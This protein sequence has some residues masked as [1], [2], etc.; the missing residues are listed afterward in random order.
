MTATVSVLDASHPLV[1]VVITTKNEERNIER[2]LQSILAQTYQ[3]I[4]IIVVDNFSTDQT[5]EI[6]Q[7][8]T[9]K[10]YE[11]G[12]ERS[13]QRNFGMIDAA[14]GAYVIFVDADM[15]LSPALIE[16]CVARMAR[17]DCVALHI[18]EIVLGRNFW[19]QVRRFERTFYDGTP[20]DGARFFLR[21]A[22][23]EVGGFD[24]ELFTEGS[25]EDW[26]IDKLIKRVGSIAL[27]S[28]R[29]SE[30]QQWEKALSTY[31]QSR[32][33]AP[34]LRDP[35]IY[36]NESEF[37]LGKYLRK[38]SY[39]AKG[40][41]GYIRKWGKTDPDIQ[42][43][44]GIGYR[45]FGVFIEQGKWRKLLAHPGLAA[46]MYFLRFL[47]GLTFIMRKRSVAL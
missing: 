18:R 45:Y 10:V 29:S 34:S 39:Y 38:K 16:N 28:E 22:F 23:I 43:Q 33:V 27:L 1:S 37:E 25:G 17:G 7:R 47:V 2:C 35:H 13:A 11:K 40:F 14:S 9:S 31:V 4:E 32:G 6:A 3:P 12:P 15:I 46:G 5:R 8:Y 44:F 24:A 41:D 36:H 21:S 26:D 20:I 42:R 30:D 19:S